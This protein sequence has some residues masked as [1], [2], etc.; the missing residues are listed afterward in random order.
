MRVQIISTILVLLVITSCKKTEEITPDYQRISISTN[1]LN[2]VFFL[3]DST[4][5]ACSGIED[6]EGRIFKTDGSGWSEVMYTDRTNV[7]SVY[8]SP[9]GKSYAGGDFVHLYTSADGGNNWGLDWMGEG[10]LSTHEHNRVSID[11]FHFVNDSVGFF[12]GGDRYEHGHIYRTTNNGTDWSFDTIRN[13][14]TGLDQVNQST[15]LFSGY[16]YVS[17]STDSGQN[18][19]Q[20]P[21]YNDFFVG[22]HVI[23]P[24]HY[25]LIGQSGKV[26]STTDSAANWNKISRIRGV[27]ILDTEQAQGKIIVVGSDGICYYST[28]AG[29]NWKRL[30]LGTTDHL[31]GVSIAGQFLNVCSSGGNLYRISLTAL[32]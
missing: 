2:D 18:I 15:M 8:V 3:D 31:N 17:K 32:I 30:N 28:D 21:V 27:N 24:T 7:L 5:F 16:G 14:V 19:S 13:E 4:G 1:P 23:S 12:V 26:Y 25:L 6:I 9:S 22:I 20:L 11:K 10:E 29:N